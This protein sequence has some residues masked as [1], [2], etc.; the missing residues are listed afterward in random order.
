MAR[1]RYL[2]RSTALAFLLQSSHIS[3]QFAGDEHLRLNTSGSLIIADSGDLVI[4]RA[5][6]SDAGVYSCLAAHQ[7]VVV[8]SLG[9]RDVPSRVT[10]MSVHTNSVFAVG[11]WWVGVAQS[12]ASPPVTWDTPGPEHGLQVE[13]FLCQNRRDT[14]HLPGPSSSQDLEYRQQELPATASQCAVY[15]LLPNTTYFFGVA[16]HNRLGR[17]DWVSL[18]ATTRPLVR[19]LGVPPALEEQGYGRLL[20]VCLSVSLLALL[21]LGSGIALLM[22]RRGTQVPARPLQVRQVPGPAHMSPQDQEDKEEAL[23]LV[24]NITLNPS[25]NIDMLEHVGEE[26]SRYTPH[27]AH[28]SWTLCSEH[29][30]LVDHGGQGG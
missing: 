23:E 9:V 28:L 4:P 30:F 1:R 24:P 18:Q 3:W 21:T 6:L 22:V 17:G 29:A 26:E 8:V 25:F 14:S 20:A 11:E 27:C 15:H 7:P 16:A 10:N 2:L 5:R 19:S 13:G 12:S